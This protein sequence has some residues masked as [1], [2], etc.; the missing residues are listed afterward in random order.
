MSNTIVFLEG[1]LTADSKENKIAVGRIKGLGLN[2]ATL[3]WDTLYQLQNG[4]TTK[5]HA[6]KDV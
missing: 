3:S 5:L 1:A 2:L 4:A 6:R